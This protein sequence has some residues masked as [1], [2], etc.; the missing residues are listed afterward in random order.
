MLFIE[1]QGSFL[2]L[3]QPGCKDNHF[4]P[5]STEV[6][7]EWIYTSTPLYALMVWTGTTLTFIMNVAYKEQDKSSALSVS[8]F[9]DLK[10]CIKLLCLF[11]IFV[12]SIVHS[13]C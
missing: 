5:S 11:S 13:D 6:K 2:G 3:K 7:N 1:Y 9:V 10:K 8:N 4:P 12:T